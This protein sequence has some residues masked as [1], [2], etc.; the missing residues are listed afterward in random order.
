MKRDLESNPSTPLTAFTYV[1]HK[2]S[3]L[4]TGPAQSAVLLSACPQL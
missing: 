3:L 4:K 1:C 2:V